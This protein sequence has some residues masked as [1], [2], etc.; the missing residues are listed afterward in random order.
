MAVDLEKIKSKLDYQNIEYKKNFQYVEGRNPTIFEKQ[1]KKDPDNRIPIPLAKT[2]V[3][4][5]SGFAAPPGAIQVNYPLKDEGDQETEYEQIISRWESEN[6]DDVEIS[7]LYRECLGQ[8]RAY[9]IFWISQE[10]DPDTSI[11][12][13]WKMV[14]GHEVYI[15]WTNDLKPKKEYAVRFWENDDEKYAQVYYPLYSEGYA[16]DGSW[17]RVEEMDTVYPFTDVP[18]IE[19]KINR[20]C[21]PMFA[22]EKTIIDKH[23]AIISATQDEVDRFNAL[24]LL[25]PGKITKEFIDKMTEMKALQ[26]LEMY[27]GDK[28]PRFLEK[29]LAGVTEFYRT[30]TDRLERLFHKSIGIPD[31]SSS[32]FAAGDESGVARAFKLLSMEYKAAMFEMYF[33][34]GLKERKG[35]FDDIFRSASGT[36]NEDDYKTEII[37]KR[38]LPID[39]AAKVNVALTLKGLGLSDEVVFKYLPNEILED[40]KAEI[41]RQEVEPEPEIIID[42]DA[43]E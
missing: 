11:K 30:F 36:Y 22:A 33:F 24:M 31:F 20:E 37:A 9:E 2:A 17:K 16:Y 41:E 23:D 1:R 14:P 21:Q 7:E 32:D 25:F 10:D 43:T 5:M 4:T 42:E 18:I 19:Y 26:E 27:D 39:E 34:Q 40:W 38:N 29:D 6:E 28:W 12:P 3:D 13:E 35:F 15:K 8:G